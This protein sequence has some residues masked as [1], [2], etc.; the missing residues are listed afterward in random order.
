MH[1]RKF[2]CFLA[3]IGLAFI[4]HAQIVEVTG[5]VTDNYGLPVPNAS[6]QEKGSKKGTV[7]DMNGNFHISISKGQ[8]LRV[9]SVGF[10]TKDA[11][12]SGTGAFNVSLVPANQSLSE[13]VVTGVGV[14]TSKKKLGIA[15]ESIS[16]DKLPP[17]PSA[18]IDQALVGKVP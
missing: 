3:S 17:T 1:M 14:A 2:I 9:S 4:S 15:V 13:V 18:S 7:T 8:T 5:K 11:P 6:V 12:V 16:A 10:E